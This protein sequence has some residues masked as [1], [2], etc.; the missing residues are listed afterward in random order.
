MSS[1]TQPPSTEVVPF[2]VIAVGHIAVNTSDLA[3]F[4]TFYEGLLGLPHVITLRESQPPHL[5]Y[6]VFAIGRDLA[7]QAYDTVIIAYEVPG[8]DPDA[9]GFGTEMGRRGRIDHFALGVADEAALL[10]VRDRLV[11]AGAADGDVLAMGPYLSAHFRDPDGL[12]GQITC[13][14]PR[15]DPS[16]VDDELIECSGPQWTDNLLHR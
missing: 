9:D 10:E 8:Y 7:R 3:R 4:R 16:R 11:A 2:P 1:T 12:A 14:N 13:P 6:G 15:F 5:Q